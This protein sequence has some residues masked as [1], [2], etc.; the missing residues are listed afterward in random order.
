MRDLQD[1]IE[2]LNY[3]LEDM[4]DV[5]K[6]ATLK[7]IFNKTDIGAVN[8]LMKSMNGEWET[9]KG[10]INDCDGSAKKMAETM[11]DNLKGKITILQSALE[12][13]GVS[14]YEV[15]DDDAKDAVDGATDAVG[16]LTESVKSG[17]LNVSLTKMSDAMDRLI[18]SAVDWT[19][20]NLPKIIDGFT[21]MIESADTLIPI[22]EGVVTGL[23]AFK[24]ATTSVAAAQAV[25]SAYTTITTAAAAAQKGLNVAVAANPFILLGSVLAGLVVT[26]IKLNDNLYDLEG[27]ITETDKASDRL[28]RTSKTLNDTL[29]RTSDERKDNAS[30]LEAEQKV[31]EGLVNRLSD[32]QKEYKNGADNMT[33]MKSVVDQLNSSL[34]GLNLA[35]DEETGELNQSTEALKANVEQLMLRQK[36]KAAEADLVQIAEE[37][38][39]AEKQ[40][41]ELEAQKAKQDEELA[42]AQERLNEITEDGTEIFETNGQA[43]TDAQMATKSATQQNE[44]LAEQIEATKET[45]ENLSAEYETATNYI[46][47]NSKSLGDDASALANVGDQ[48]ELTAGQLYVMSDGFADITNNLYESVQKTLESSNDLF[49]KTTEIQQQNIDDMRKNVEDHVKQIEGWRDSYTELASRVDTESGAILEYLANMGVEGKGYIDELLTLDDAELNEFVSQMEDAM[50]LPSEIAS[51]VADS[52]RT[53]IQESIDGMREVAESAASNN[54]ELRKAEKE[55]AKSFVEEL[56][57]ELGPEER[58]MAE[59]IEEAYGAMIEAIEDAQPK[60]EEDSEE[61]AAA[62]TDPIEENVTYDAFYDY[63]EK[64]G[65]GLEDGLRS[66]IKDVLKAAEELAQQLTKVYRVLKV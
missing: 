43:L 48:A 46:N 1:V 40:L 54:S 3:S 60:V 35:I 66:K 37:Q 6:S 27:G 7:Q 44:D 18:D 26:T 57:E 34:P 24:A 31:T 39:K 29:K 58:L 5:E 25:M 19:E 56:E 32:L 10:N 42:N 12:G 36:V 61:M 59:H 8:A 52:Y 41:A 17:D 22:V 28:A 23:I 64:A 33:E 65:E 4:G 50:K 51:E 38:Y 13:L 62:A 47:D 15:F 63:A 30:S 49:S 14:V 20:K 9:L 21:G 45:I 53:A 2:D 16:R 11:N 55:V